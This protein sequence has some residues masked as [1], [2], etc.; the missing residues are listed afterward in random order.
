MTQT[1]AAP[2]ALPHPGRAGI[3]VLYTAIMASGMA[4]ALV[5]ILIPLVGRE[6]KLNELTVDIPLLHILWQ[7]HELVI[8]ALT[9]LTSVIYSIATPVWGRLS[10][11]WGRRRVI[12]VGLLGYCVGTLA[13]NGIVELGLRGVVT[14]FGL[15]LALAL[16]RV[17]YATTMAGLTPASS[18]YIADITTPAQRMGGL[19]KL[20]AANQ[21]GAMI[22]PV[23]TVTA[24]ISLLTPMYIYAFITVLMALLTWRFLPETAV[25]I[26]HHEPRAH[27]RFMDPRYRQLLAVGFIMCAMMGMAQ[28]TLVFYFQDTLHLST[29]DAVKR[30]SVASVITASAMVLT[31]L[32]V[33]QRLGFGPL[34]L[35]RVGLPIAFVSY[36]LLASATSLIQLWSAMA[37]FGLGMGMCLPGFGASA[38]LRVGPSEQG[39]LAGISGATVGWGFLFGPLIGG[40]L[41]GQQHTLPY[42]CAASIMA[43]LSIFVWRQ[44]G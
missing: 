19:G 37:L 28:S 38:S 2:L 13:F 43:P 24:S 12:V 32:V 17:V 29:Q 4:Q 14:G 18:A 26:E 8:T 31:Q 20:N 41:Y 9:A 5:F 16:S 36:L 10:D 11:R 39:A 7:P 1:A 40:F 44:R 21:I 27:L 15:Y 25:R 34:R 35:L 30:Y 22:G 33:V 6:L 3:A 23:L 42:W